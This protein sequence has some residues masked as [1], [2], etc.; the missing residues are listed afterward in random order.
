MPG[1]KNEELE[2]QVKLVREGFARKVAGICKRGTVGQKRRRLASLVNKETFPGYDRGR[3]GRKRMA[4]QLAREGRRVSC[5]V[6][7]AKVKLKSRRTVW[8]NYYRG[9]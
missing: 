3:S 5:Q 6:F 1:N 2:I 9:K 4:R 7:R 8:P